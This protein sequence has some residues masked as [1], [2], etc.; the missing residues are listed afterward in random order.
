MVSWLIDPIVFAEEKIPG[1]FKHPIAVQEVLTG[2][3]TAANAAW[4]GFDKSESTEALQGAI[5]SG[6]SKVIV[7]YMGSDWIVR[8]IHLVSNQEIVFEPGVV[9]SAKKGDF[10]GK[11]DC[12]F[13]GRGLSNVTLRGYGAVLRMRKA[14]YM[15]PPYTKSEHRHVV[16]FA[17]SNNINII[18]LRLE[19]SG[20][21]GIFIGPKRRALHIPCKNV[22]IEDCICDNNYRQGISVTAVDG[23]RIDNC[24]LK[25]TQ[26]TLPQAGIDLE[27]SNF[28]GMLRKVVVSNCVSE[29]NVGQGFVVNVGSLTSTSKE[30]S[31]L[32]VNCLARSTGSISVYAGREANHPTGLVEFRN[33]VFEDIVTRGLDVFWEKFACPIMVRFRDC[34]WKNVATKQHKYPLRIILRSK[35]YSNQSEGIE[36]VNCYVYDQRDRPFLKVIERGGSGDIYDIKGDIKVYNP[37]GAR[38]DLGPTAKKLAL[39][40]NSFKT[41]K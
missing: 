7:P 22:V 39:K 10:K 41:L 28:K 18:G 17:G 21:D 2:K 29:N 6:A 32:F 36:F 15:M 5:N 4:W 24:L 19:S 33:C 9:V 23:M 35:E 8:P 1:N 13:A 25:N 30:V 20:G 12:L 16:S 3:R 40:V 34:K 14:D 27:P 38:I 31:V 11:Y 26:G 37:Y